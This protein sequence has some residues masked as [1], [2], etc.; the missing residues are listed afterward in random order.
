MSKYDYHYR[1]AEEAAQARHD[2]LMDIAFAIV[3]GVAGAAF[4]F[5]WLS[6]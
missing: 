4:L 5:L 2:K 6:K 3:L 1:P